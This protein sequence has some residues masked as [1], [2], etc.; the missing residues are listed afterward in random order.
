MRKKSV[1]SEGVHSCDVSHVWTATKKAYS[2]KLEGRCW[3]QSHNPSI[4][5]NTALI[6]AQIQN[7]EPNLKLFSLI[8]FMLGKAQTGLSIINKFSF[9]NQKEKTLQQL[10]TQVIVKMHFGNCLNLQQV[11]GRGGFKQNTCSWWWIHSCWMYHR[12][13]GSQAWL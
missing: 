12:V 7:L 8:S 6:L 2:S 1:N 11:K 10:T 4:N 5:A 13:I 3:H 9:K